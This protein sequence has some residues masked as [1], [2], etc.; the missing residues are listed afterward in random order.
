MALVHINQWHIFIETIV[1][2]LTNTNGIRIG[3]G[4]LKTLVEFL[5]LH[6]EN[7]GDGQYI[8][9]FCPTG[10]KMNNV[11]VVYTKWANLKKTQGMDVGQVGFHKQK[12]VN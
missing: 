8:V 5:P 6:V 1:T 7:T 4:L 9:S 11:D 3:W 10:N 12:E 2:L